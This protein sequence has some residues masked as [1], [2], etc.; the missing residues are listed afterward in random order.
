LIAEDIDFGDRGTAK[1]TF[2]FKPQGNST[3]LNWGFDVEVGANPVLRIMGS[4]VD[5]MVG[6]D[7]E[8]GLSN[9]KNK[10]ESISVNS[11]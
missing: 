1:C 11:Y 5:G 4:F 6:K 9:L 7:F 2:R 3:I 8:I 10:V